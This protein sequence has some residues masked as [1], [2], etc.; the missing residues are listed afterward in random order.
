MKKFQTI[1]ASLIGWTALKTKDGQIDLSEEEKGSLFEKLGEEDATLLI[2]TA[3]EELS[4]VKSAKDQL[5]ELKT[6]L[7]AATKNSNASLQDAGESNDVASENL[8]SMVEALQLKIKEQEKLINKLKDEP[9]TP[10]PAGTMR[11][12]AVAAGLATA[13]FAERLSLR[14][15]LAALVADRRHIR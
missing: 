10:S 4:E 3:N 5:A 15:W 1:L 7:E 6:Q 14:L 9:E 8:G 11:N 2:A 13:V 12:L